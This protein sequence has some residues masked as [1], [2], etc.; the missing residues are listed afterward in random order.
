MIIL[1]SSSPRRIELL[2]KYYKDFIIIR[3]NFDE[4]KIDKINEHF[5]MLESYN[6]A[7]SILNPTYFNDLIIGADTIVVYNKKIYGKPANLDE[8]KLFLSILSNQTHQVITGY[9]LLYKGKE[10]KKEI[11]TEVTFNKLSKNDIENY[12]NSENVL[13]KAGAY[14]IQDDEK[15][16]LIKSIKGSL[17]NVIGFPIEEIKKDID[18]LLSDL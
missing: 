17:N 8:A 12:V 18:Y 13:D 15:F 9:T 1:A 7:K 6:K 11:I 3:P 4:S 2:K 10:I 14:A 16:H 5:A